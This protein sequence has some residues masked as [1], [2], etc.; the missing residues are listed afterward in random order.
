MKVRRAPVPEM[1]ET[2]DLIKNSITYD[3]GQIYQ[4]LKD[5]AL[6]GILFF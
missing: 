6:C 1:A 5:A 4:I 2:V 3:M